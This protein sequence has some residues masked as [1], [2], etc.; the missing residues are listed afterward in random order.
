MTIFIIARGYPSQR[1][2]Q[3]GCF[4]KDQAEALAQYGHKVVILSVDSRFRFYWRRLGIQFSLQNNIPAYNIFIIPGAIT[5]LFFG[6]RVNAR[7]K[8]WLLDRIYQKAVK[9]YGKPDI[10]YSHYLPTTQMATHLKQ[11]YNIPLVGIEHWSE[12]GYNP[13]QPNIIP[14]AQYTY[15]HIDQLLT[16]SSALQKNI[17]E[18]LQTTSL[19]VCNMV[20]TEFVYKPTKKTHTSVRFVTTGSLLYVKGIDVLLNALSYIPSQINW[21]LF[22]IG[23]GKLQ[24]DLK[25]LTQTLGIGNKVHFCGKKNKQ[26]I[27][28]LYHTCDAYI[29]AS[30]SETFGVAIIEAL[31]CGLP[32]IS[33]MSGG[34][35]DIINSTNGILVPVNDA[36]A[37]AEAI[38]KMVSTYSTYNHQAIAEDCQA[39][40]SPK[41]IAQQLT[42]IFRQVI[43]S[44]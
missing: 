41:V 22:I 33:T 43:S 27:V 1:T 17:Q 14:M 21:E 12:M 8:A 37:L 40:F 3:W 44:Q 2:P 36:N 30:R 28:K 16:V 31:A 10:L 25:Q 42:E 13:I 11:K 35:A 7:L 26:E 4:E 9:Q 24:N 5:S 6:K 20:G 18:Q 34:P 32:V 19:V 23:T 38:K 29:S 15:R 39:R